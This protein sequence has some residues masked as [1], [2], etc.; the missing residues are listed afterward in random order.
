MTIIGCDDFLPTSDAEEHALKRR[1]LDRALTLGPFVGAMMQGIWVD[2]IHS[3]VSQTQRLFS[4]ATLHGHIRLDAAC[5][6]AL[7]Y[8]RTH[9]FV[10]EEILRED[11]QSLP[12]NPYTD[13]FGHLRPEQLISPGSQPLAPTEAPS[14]RDLP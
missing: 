8:R 3:T 4:L 7:Y 9:L 2:F 6:R 5:R 10:V 1:L 14:G 11:A 12:L 13:V